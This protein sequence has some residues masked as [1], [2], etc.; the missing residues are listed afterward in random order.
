MYK[1][2]SIDKPI[3]QVNVLRLR[4]ECQMLKLAPSTEIAK[5]RKAKCV[6]ALIAYAETGS[7]TEPVQTTTSI[8][9]PEPEPA[10]KPVYPKMVEGKFTKNGKVYSALEM[11]I[12]DIVNDRLND[13]LKEYEP[14]AQPEIDMLEVAKMVSSEVRK[15][16][17][18]VLEIKKQDSEPV[19]IEGY[20]PNWFND[21]LKALSAGLNVLVSGPAGCGKT[22]TA[23]L[24][25]EALNLRFAHLSLSAGASESWLLGRYLPNTHG[26]FEYQLSQFVDYYENGGLFLLDEIDAADAN[27]LIIINAA[28]ANGKMSVPNRVDNP[29]AKRH[30]D[31]KLIAA[32]NTFG[33]GMDR[34]YAGRVQLDAAF[35]DRWVMFEAE[36][37]TQLETA[38]AGDCDDVLTLI[39][40]MREKVSKHKMRRVIS[41]RKLMQLVTLRKNGFSFSKCRDVLL[42]GWSADEKRKVGV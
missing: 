3:E 26:G 2:E 27:M 15:V 18:Q 40:E 28:I 10:S 13:R 8:A 37:N 34:M 5:W 12:L 38:L 29:I 4:K 39:N 42:T 35:L 14:S 7:Y 24:L 23:A 33:Q 16:T 20:L 25:A 30:P 6:Q 11:S 21:A 41:T 32:A 36:Y 9:E 1:I 31:F 17:P 19:K 22:H